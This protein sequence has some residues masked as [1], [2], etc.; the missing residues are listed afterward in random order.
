[1]PEQTYMLV[2]CSNMCIIMYNSE[3]SFGFCG[4]LL[5]LLVQFY[6]LTVL[7]FLTFTFSLSESL[8]ISTI[9]TFSYSSARRFPVHLA[10]NLTYVCGCIYNLFFY[11]WWYCLLIF[12]CQ[13]RHLP[14]FSRQFSMKNHL[15]VHLNYPFHK[16]HH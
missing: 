9:N 1:M 7:H 8:L 15:N 3:L 14:H 11:T 13:H 12:P 4:S 5:P 6:F 16:F 2:L 10:K